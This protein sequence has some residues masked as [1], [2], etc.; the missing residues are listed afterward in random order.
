MHL[1]DSFGV[2]PLS[3]FDNRNS[4]FF[5]CGK[6]SA[7]ETTRIVSAF[8]PV[9]AFSILGRAAFIVKTSLAFTSDM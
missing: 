9:T 2:L 8:V 1:S 7:G 6:E 3:L 5:G 4:A